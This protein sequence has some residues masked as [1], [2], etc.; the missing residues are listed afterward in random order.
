MNKIAFRDEHDSLGM[1]QVPAAA[2]YGAQTMRAVGNFP[3][4]GLRAHAELITAT[5]QVK[6]AAA[7]ANAHLEIG[8]AHV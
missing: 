8:R 6:K 2:Y 3:I 1:V 4:S 5:V 7:R